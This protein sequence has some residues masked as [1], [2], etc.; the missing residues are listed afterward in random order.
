MN[1]EDKSYVSK[2]KNERMCWCCCKKIVIYKW[3]TYYMI[4]CDIINLIHYVW[5]AIFVKQT[6]LVN[7]GLTNSGQTWALN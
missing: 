7:S 2:L 4:G 3:L 6:L 5:S 1:E